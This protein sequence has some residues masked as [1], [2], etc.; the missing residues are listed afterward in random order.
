LISC[1]HRK[2][3]PKK[4]SRS[5][6][7]TPTEPIEKS[8]KVGLD[9]WAAIEICLQKSDLFREYRQAFGGTIGLPLVLRAAGSF[10]APL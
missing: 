2:I 1:F 9:V 4:S 10:Q 5:L 7:V 6:R 8:P 3:S